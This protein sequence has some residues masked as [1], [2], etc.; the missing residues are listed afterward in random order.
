[1]L[2]RHIL[3]D[4]DKNSTSK[5]TRFAI[6]GRFPTSTDVARLLGRAVQAIVAATTSLT[7]MTWTTWPCDSSITC[8]HGGCSPANADGSDLTYQRPGPCRDEEMRAAGNTAPR[9]RRTA[10]RPH[11]RRPRRDRGMSRF[12]RR[13]LFGP[14]PACCSPVIVCVVIWVGL[15]PK[16]T[17]AFATQF[18]RYTAGSRWRTSP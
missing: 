7:V 11:P 9:Y 14:R 10:H 8:P 6:R 3:L 12:R 2:S 1:M 15:G 16:P 17:R 5:L 18:A 13:P 4:W